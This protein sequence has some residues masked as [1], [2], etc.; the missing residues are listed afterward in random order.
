ARR[1]VPGDPEARRLVRLRIPRRVETR[2]QALPRSPAPPP[3]PARAVPRAQRRQQA[4]RDARLPRRDSARSAAADHDHQAVGR[5]DVGVAESP[6]MSTIHIIGVPLDLGAGR[7][8]VEMGP[9][10][11]R[12]AGLGERIA[13]LG[14]A[15]VDKGNLPTPIPETQ[16]ARDEHKKYIREIAKVC[17]KLYQ[18]AGASL[19]EGA[20]PLVLGGDHSLA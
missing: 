8:G 10:A 5:G 3:W 6:M 7:R 1:C 11:I 14:H 18:T 9:S 20:M 19:D 15:V 17:T 2:L 16:D 4:G 12:S 13:A